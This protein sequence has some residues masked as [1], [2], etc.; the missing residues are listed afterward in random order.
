LP[1]AQHFIS[2]YMKSYKE[3]PDV[4]EIPHFTILEPGAAALIQRQ[5]KLRE[6]ERQTSAFDGFKNPRRNKKEETKKRS[7]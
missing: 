1:S 3:F 6:Q 7:R 4:S 2:W 5:Q